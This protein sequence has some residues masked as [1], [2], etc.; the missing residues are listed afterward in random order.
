MLK[1]GSY[2]QSTCIAVSRMPACLQASYLQVW[3][4]GWFLGDFWLLERNIVPIGRREE[5]QPDIDR[6]IP[7]DVG[8]AHVSL[9]KQMLAVLALVI[10]DF[11]GQL[12]V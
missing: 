1:L 12:G 3:R 2:A 5:R 10:Q 9:A 4:I 6:L 11:H 8:A 7:L